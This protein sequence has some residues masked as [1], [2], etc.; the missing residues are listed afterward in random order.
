MTDLDLDGWRASNPDAPAGLLEAFAAY[1]RALGDDD[2]QRII[3]EEIA[4]A[5]T[6]GAQGMKAMGKVVAAVRAQAGPT[7][8]GAK[9]AAMVK[10]ALA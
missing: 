1:E 4:A 2:L 3:G 6:S 8:D 10:A 5:A 7:A 9:I